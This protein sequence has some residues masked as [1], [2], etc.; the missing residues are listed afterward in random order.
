MALSRPMRPTLN[1]RVIA[2]ILAVLWLPAVWHCELE[3][4]QV[5]ADEH[6]CC[7]HDGTADGAAGGACVS[8]PCAIFDEG[9]VRGG[10]EWTVNV[11]PPLVAALLPLWEQSMMEPTAVLRPAHPPPDPVPHAKAWVFVCRKAP[12][13]NAPGHSVS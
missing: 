2:L 1:L 10:E 11:L 8:D 12:L 13:A 6:G 9:H 3:T 7:S 4:L 5:A